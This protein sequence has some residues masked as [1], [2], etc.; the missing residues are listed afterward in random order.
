MSAEPRAADPP[1]L[2]L[3]EG[4]RLSLLG[5]ISVAFFTTC[6]GAFALEALIGAVGPG[7]AFV[8][9]FLTPVL[10][11]VPIAL[12]VAELS[13]LLPE[14]GGYYVWVRDSLGPFWALQEA[15]WTLGSSLMLMAIFPVI[16]SAYLGY[17][18]RQV[19]AAMQLPGSG[20]V[21]R[22][23]I[24]LAVIGTSLGVNWSGARNVGSSSKVAITFVLGTFIALVVVFLAKGGGLGI[25][26]AILRRDLA[27][28]HQGVLLLGL[29]I[30]ILNYGGYDNIATYASEV[31]LPPHQR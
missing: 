5:L 17:L 22:W 18:L 27:A 28:E 21:V 26:F 3:A 24:A 10:W 8:L 7:W 1:P 20:A 30:V 14:E 19:G 12:M 11:S 29:S 16:F 23:L 2:R 9:L 6:G 4:R 25:P 31:D 15:C 13:A